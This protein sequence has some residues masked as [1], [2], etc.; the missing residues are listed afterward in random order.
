[1]LVPVLQLF[2]AVV[3]TYKYQV[4]RRLQQATAAA[5]EYWLCFL[6]IAFRCA[7]WRAAV[8][9]CALCNMLLCVLRHSHFAPLDGR[10]HGTITKQ[11]EGLC[12]QPSLMH[13]QQQW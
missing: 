2:K 9:L 7:C 5:Y 10:M 6:A 1:M 11:Y 13:R 12:F 8:A 4:V 3:F